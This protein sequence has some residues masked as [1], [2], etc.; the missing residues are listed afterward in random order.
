MQIRFLKSNDPLWEEVAHFASCCSWKSGARLAGRMR[1][2][3]FSD[4]E[5][6]LAAL[7]DDGSVMGF[8]TVVKVDCLLDSPFM[9]FIGS[10]FVDEA[11]RGHRLS[12]KLI[13]KAK[14]YLKTQSFDKV[15]ICS[16]AI[17]LYEKYGFVKLGEYPKY[18]GKM[19]QLFVCDL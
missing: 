16:G 7:D 2:G 17:G 4:W 8:C 9:P 12:G 13:E 5:C 11:Y 6:V 15:Y 1:S 14:E 18:N 10:M 19:E 3:D